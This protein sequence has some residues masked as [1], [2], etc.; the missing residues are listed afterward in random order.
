VRAELLEVRG[1]GSLQRRAM[2]AAIAGGLGERGAGGEAERQDGAEGRGDPGFELEVHGVSPTDDA[3]AARALA[4][5]AG[6]SIPAQIAAVFRSL[7]FM[8]RDGALL[9]R[10]RLLG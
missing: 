4:P 1:A 10:H 8:G 2:A 9:R 3:T 5:R 6:R 7:R